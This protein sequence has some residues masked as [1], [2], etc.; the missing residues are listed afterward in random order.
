[1]DGHIFS[2]CALLFFLLILTGST[3]KKQHDHV[4]LMFSPLRKG[5][6]GKITQDL[7]SKYVKGIHI[8]LF[9][10]TSK[11]KTSTTHRPSLAP[12]SAPRSVLPYST[13]T[14]P[15]HESH[16]LSTQIPRRRRSKNPCQ[17]RWRGTARRL[18]D[19]VPGLQNGCDDRDEKTL[20]FT[21]VQ[22]TRAAD[23]SAGA[24]R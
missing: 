2:F 4:R 5:E 8:F 9:E 15:F 10:N 20:S 11:H 23:W 21:C 13:T 19:I 16:G 7:F 3:K 14:K 1:M 17:S 24:G 12:H 22:P 6:R 18:F